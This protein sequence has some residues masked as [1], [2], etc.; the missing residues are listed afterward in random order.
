MEK[1]IVIGHL[2]FPPE[3]VEAVLPELK[4]FVDATRQHDSCISYNVAEDIFEAGLIHFSEVW[5]DHESLSAHL[6]SP[7]ILPWRKATKQHGLLERTFFAYSS[8]ESRP[9]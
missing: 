9:V 8:Q 5:P 1:I 7:H 2:R 4:I 6:N 3:S